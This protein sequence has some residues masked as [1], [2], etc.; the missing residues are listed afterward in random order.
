M[1]RGLPQWW[2]AKRAITS[3]GRL[4]EKRRFVGGTKE[5]WLAGCA[6]D[7]AKNGKKGEVGANG[8][9]PLKVHE[10]REVQLP[11]NG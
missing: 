1:P 5:D 3:E 9:R 4:L 7:D 11:W 6:V 2:A 8:N 10:I